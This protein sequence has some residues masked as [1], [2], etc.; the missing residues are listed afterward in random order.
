MFAYRQT[1]D[2]EEPSFKIVKI[3]TF[4]KFSRLKFDNSLTLKQSN[5]LTPTEFQKYKIFSFL[6]IAMF[7][8]AKRALQYWNI[9]INSSIYRAKISKQ[10]LRKK[11][12][13]LS[14]SEFA[15]FSNLMF[16]NPCGYR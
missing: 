14:N 16:R 7:G 6:Y 4:L 1:I 2:M 8:E 5:F 3:H 15:I 10:G 11:I 9:E 12:A 13:C